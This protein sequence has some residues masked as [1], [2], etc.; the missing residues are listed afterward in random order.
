PT[1]DLAAGEPNYV[2]RSTWL[3]INIDLSG[4]TKS[5][6]CRGLLQLALS[7]AGPT[8]RVCDQWRWPTR[9]LWCCRTSES[10]SANLVRGA[11]GGNLPQAK[12]YAILRHEFGLKL[13]PAKREC[14]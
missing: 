10:G 1:S 11:G 3:V 2:V 14:R 8:P 6:P 4:V 13:T 12:T 9:V 7:Q 5:R